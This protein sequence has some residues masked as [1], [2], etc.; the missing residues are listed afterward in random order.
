MTTDSRQI[1]VYA[2]SDCTDFLR[3]QEVFR[4]HSIDFTFV[5]VL[6]SAEAAERAQHI[7]GG[8]STPVI[9]FPDGSFQVE[10]TDPELE[11]KILDL[12][13]A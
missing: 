10:P 9:V 7:S 1:T 4:K 11:A 13:A 2:K 8:P 5:N 3:S 12:D 6:E